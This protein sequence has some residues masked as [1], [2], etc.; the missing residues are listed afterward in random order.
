MVLLW[1]AFLFFL[2]CCP[3]SGS[4]NKCDEVRKLFH[5][6]P[7]GAGQPSGP[8]AESDLQVCVSKNLSCCTK[9]MEEKYQLVARRD[10]QNLLQ[11]SSSKLKSLISQ[12]VAAFQGKQPP[13]EPAFLDV[14]SAAWG[15]LPLFTA[16]FESGLDWAIVRVSRRAGLRAC[17]PPKHRIYRMITVILLRFLQQSWVKITGVC[18]NF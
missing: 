11:S 9:K 10:I 2:L 17:C 15:C 12:N 14:C 1:I 16:V 18:I 6:R 13:L 8:G 5:H 4:P 3:G 7:T